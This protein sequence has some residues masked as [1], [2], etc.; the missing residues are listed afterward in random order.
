M[1][2]MTQ[3]TDSRRQQDGAAPVDLDDVPL[4]PDLPPLPSLPSG[5]RGIE[6][7]RVWLTGS[8]KTA[9]VVLQKMLRMQW[10]G[11]VMLAMALFAVSS[12]GVATLSMKGVAPVLKGSWRAQATFLYMLPLFMYQLVRTRPSQLRSF[13][14]DRSL[15]LNFAVVTMGGI[16]WAATFFVAL[17]YTSLAHAYLFSNIT[18]I[19]IVLYRMAARLPVARLEAIGAFVG[20]LGGALTIMG[21]DALDPAD[22]TPPPLNQIVLGDFIAFLGSIGGVFYLMF[23]SNLRAKVPIFIY[24]LP[25]TLCNCIFFVVLSTLLEVKDVADFGGIESLS[26][27]VL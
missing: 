13:V 22:T 24:M 16:T 1:Q 7:T 3:C 15:V 11:Y 2:D 9:R 10:P 23:G 21:R 27:G 20:V 25:L 8:F 14:L 6:N 5:V 19:L 17:Q 4:L 18:C 26:Y 12:M